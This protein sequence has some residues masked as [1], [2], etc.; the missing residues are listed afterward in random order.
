MRVLVNYPDFVDENN[1]LQDG[2]KVIDVN[3]D[4][5][6]LN[7]IKEVYESKKV[8]HVHLQFGS[9][10]ENKNFIFAGEVIIPFTKDVHPYVVL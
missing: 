10:D 1:M 3:N 2:T 4:Q 5:E 8:N 7:V 9:Y 6:L